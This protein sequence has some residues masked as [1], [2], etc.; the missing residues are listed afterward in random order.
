MVVLLLVVVLYELFLR[1]SPFAQGITPMEYDAEI[2]MWHKRNFKGVISKS[3]YH[4][5]YEFDAMGRVK[6]LVMNDAK[7]NIV[8]L[9]DSQVEALMVSNESIV[10]NRLSEYLNG[11][12]NVL[13]YGLSGTG[14][15]QQLIILKSKIDLKK[16]EHV[17]HFVF[18]ENDLNDGDSGNF[19]RINRPK[20]FV[21]F[22]DADHY[23]IVKPRSYDGIER[24][25]DFLGQLELYVYLKKT[26]YHY[27]D[28][29]TS[30]QAKPVERVPAETVSSVIPGSDRLWLNLFGAIYQANQAAQKNDAKYSVIIYSNDYETEK[31]STKLNKLTAY[32]TQ[33]KINFYPLNP[34]IEN[35]PALERGFECD[36]HWNASTHDLI[37]KWLHKI[38]VKN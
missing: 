23:N 29:L 32:L 8:L 1:Y 14:P 30:A 18:I 36:G 38:I 27:R 15:G 26:V 3:C 9:G 28:L 35:I 11:Q 31:N 6:S 7:S 5:S 12:Y 17:I 16:L 13:N 20:V 37:A 19:D 25:R 22:S 2:G 34:L 21:N 10:H 4:Q 33:Q 24:V